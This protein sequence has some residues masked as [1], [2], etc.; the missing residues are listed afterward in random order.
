[1]TDF[2]TDDMGKNQIK[3]PSSNFSTTG[4]VTSSKQSASA[5]LEAALLQMDDIISG[6]QFFKK[7]DAMGDL[8]HSLRDTVKNLVG[9]LQSSPV[10]PARPDERTV[11]LLLNWLQPERLKKLEIDRNALQME[12]AV[13]SEQIDVQMQ[14]INNLK[15]ELDSKKEVIQHMEE[16]MHKEAL[17]RS[18]LETQKLELLNSLTEMKLKQATLEHE[19]A[20]LRNTR[21]PANVGGFTRHARQ[22]CSLP[23]QPH[24]IKKG[25]VFAKEKPVIIDCSTSSVVQQPQKRICDMSTEEIC[26][27]VTNLGLGSYI[28][29]FERAKINGKFLIESTLTEL[30]KVLDIKNVLHKKKI[31]C[32][33]DCEKLKGADYFGSDKM[34]TVAVLRWLDDIGLPQHKES[35]QNAKVDGRVLNKLTTDD[36]ALLNI[37]AELHA[38][39]LRRGI[40]TLRE[41]NFKSDDLE[42]RSSN[43]NTSRL[44]EN[45]IEIEDQVKLWTNHRVMEWLRAVD[46]AEYAPN[47]RGSGVHGG[48]IIHEP[49]FNSELLAT[50]LNI[51]PAKTLLRRHLTTHFNQLIGRNI[52]KNKREIEN[53][54]TFVPLTITAKLKVQKKS[55]FTLKRKKKNNAYF[56]PLV[57]PLENTPPC[58]P[59][60]TLNSDA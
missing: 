8:Q 44:H 36:L 17:L 30:E 58:S 4:H 24:S 15:D 19:N 33:I 50:L 12:I 52:V 49:R 35:F 43:E 47:M 26:T 60:M 23:R 16:I 6:R 51:P 32:A 2:Q 39:S 41:L 10:L 20:T 13:L 55:Q 42:R 37:T 27:W 34:D 29:E 46:L 3:D 18:S 54:E 21:S 25:V 7:A 11:D 45:S 14:E 59:N 31:L 40:Q 22:Y 57:C 9:I 28:K 56:T 38:V 5:M 48:L 1:M 53:S